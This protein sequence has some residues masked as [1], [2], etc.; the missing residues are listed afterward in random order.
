M[1]M[2]RYCPKDCYPVVKDSTTAVVQRLQTS[3]GAVPQDQMRQISDVQSQLCA[4]LQVL[5][6]RLEVPDLLSISDGIV[7]VRP[8]CVTTCVGIRAGVSPCTP[9]ALSCFRSS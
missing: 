1:S 4:L 3:L 8:A 5:I 9:L 2:M 6:K 7:Q